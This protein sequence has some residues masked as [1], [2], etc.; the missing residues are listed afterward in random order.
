ML[1]VKS[2]QAEMAKK[3]CNSR[4]GKN[5]LLFSFTSHATGESS[6]TLSHGNPVSSHLHG[7]KQLFFVLL[8]DLSQSLSTF[9]FWQNAVEFQWICCLPCWQSLWVK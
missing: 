7:S 2:T 1:D 6:H 5:E 4:K 8:T 3:P 9:Y